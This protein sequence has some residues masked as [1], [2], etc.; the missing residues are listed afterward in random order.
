MGILSRVREL[1]FPA[2]CM[3][4]RRIT[5]GELICPE[6]RVRLPEYGRVR[7][8]GE[9]FSDCC[10]PLRYEGDV[11]RA[12]LRYKFNGR[13]GYAAGFA[14]L[15]ADCVSEVLEDSFDVVTWVPVSARRLR[16]RGYDQARLL[17]ELTAER[18]GVQV[19]HALRKSRHTRA[20]SSIKGREGRAAN[21]LGAYEVRDAAAVRGKRV[22]LVDDIVTTG[23]TLSECSRM[24]L[25]AGAED[26]VCAAA[27]AARK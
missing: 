15:M 17:A 10:A 25:M 19:V 26:V 1:V 5:G 24:L 23:A 12:L 9:F 14:K 27:A 20:N 16:E 11:R 7:G 21:I 6:C 2:K 18:L 3:F 8:H 4:C 22:L 13:R